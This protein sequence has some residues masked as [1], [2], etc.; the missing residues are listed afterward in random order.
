[1]KSTELDINTKELK[2]MEY[3]QVILLFGILT[4]M[5]WS[6]NTG[7][8]KKLIKEIGY[9]REYYPKDYI[10]PG[11]KIRKIFHLGKREIPKWTYWHLLLALVY[12][13]LFV[14]VVFL[15]FLT[16][17]SPVIAFVF[18]IIYI[19]LFWIDVFSAVMA[20]LMWK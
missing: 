20:Y 3:H 10:M 7:T 8:V 19:V 2:S 16:G 14:L 1:M 17:N 13:G 5:G 4:L 15:V 18:F 12:V 9:H 11:R 6:A